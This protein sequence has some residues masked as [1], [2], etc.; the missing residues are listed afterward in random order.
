MLC[1]TYEILHMLFSDPNGHVNVSPKGIKGTFKV[2]DS[3]TLMYQ[4]SD[5]SVLHV[6][7]IDILNTFQDL[8]GSGIETVAHL[9]ENGRITVLF[10]AFVGPPRICRIFGT[11]KKKITLSPLLYVMVYPHRDLA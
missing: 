5:P 9:R 11:G 7:S 3:N 6:L 1:G 2:L 8:S 4:V 10:Q